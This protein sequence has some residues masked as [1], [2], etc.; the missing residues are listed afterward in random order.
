MSNLGLIYRYE[1]KKLIK[2]KT[3]LISFVL[4]ALMTLLINLYSIVSYSVGYQG[5]NLYTIS[6]RGDYKTDYGAL[7]KGIDIYWVNDDGEFITDIFRC[8][9]NLRKSGLEKSWMMR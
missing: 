9:R 3:F 2:G 7:V 4:I 8:K 1:T 5:A 6:G